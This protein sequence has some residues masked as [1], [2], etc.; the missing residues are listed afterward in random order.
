MREQKNIR[1]QYRRITAFMLAMLLVISG[2]ACSEKQD[3][4]KKE[5]PVV[6]DD[7]TVRQL[8]DFEDTVSVIDVQNNILYGYYVNDIYGYEGNASYG[9]FSYDLDTETMKK[10]AL[11]ENEKI[12]HMY[13]EDDHFAVEVQE[14]EQEDTNAAD[15]ISDNVDTSRT[16]ESKDSEKNITDE[17]NDNDD[18][19]DDSNN[20]FDYDADDIVI[21]C[22]YD[23]NLE[24]VSDNTQ[25]NANQV[26]E[27]SENE[28][29]TTVFRK[30]D[31][32]IRFISRDRIQVLDSAGKLLRSVD[33]SGMEI[34]NVIEQGDDRFLFLGLKAKEFSYS[35]YAFSLKENGTFE[36]LDE[37]NGSLVSI[38]R[39]NAKNSL[40]VS[41]DGYLYEYALDTKKITGILRYIDNGL[42][43]NKLT[44]A[45][46]MDEE[47]YVLIFFENP[48]FCSKLAILGKNGAGEKKKE[49][50]FATMLLSDQ[51]E[52]KID[53]FNMTNEQYRIVVDDYGKADEFPTAE[54]FEKG[55]LQFQLDILYGSGADIIDL[56][57]YVD[58]DHYTNKG[59]IEDLLPYIQRDEELR[60]EDFLPNILEAYKKDGKLYY[61]PSFFSVSCIMTTPEILGEDM[62]TDVSWT[63][64]EFMEYTQELPKDMRIF[65]TYHTCENLL[66]EFIADNM[67]TLIDWKKLTC[68]FNSEEFISLLEYCKDNFLTSSE[69]SE[70]ISGQEEFEWESTR[71]MKHQ[72][73]FTMAQ[74]TPGYFALN[75]QLFGEEPVVKG[76]PSGHGT[77]LYILDNSGL[78]I[79][80]NSRSKYK[81]VIW[82]FMRQWYLYDEQ[83]KIQ[84]GAL[85][86]Y[87]AYPV[88]KDCFDAYMENIKTEELKYEIDGKRY[89]LALDEGNRT[90]CVDR[91]T[92]EMIEQA[93]WLVEMADCTSE[94]VLSPVFDIIEEETESFFAGQKT[95]KETA[96]LIQSRVSIYVSEQG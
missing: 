42:D 50:H 58:L 52:R 49:I 20:D 72:V 66:R 44:Y 87:P 94:N 62:R 39:G 71:L 91:P 75:E 28:E 13:V 85:Y 68:H 59:I 56:A 45:Y 25:K 79:G 77:G 37:F 48:S 95:A 22:L 11:G 82:E 34:K 24:A 36:K 26:F 32:Q 67:E 86:S 60:E 54:E 18:S 46:P 57:H 84:L 23:R 33:V 16:A 35:L 10:T 21:R 6:V 47:H 19:N 31:Q 93:K 65:D 76:F 17:M 8:T 73:A 4:K 53:A 41:K 38:F 80:I 29:E 69:V 74:V 51:M 1:W 64:E 70:I 55:L 40:L 90:I 12:L 9:L 30:G 15:C 92:D 89:Y 83:S 7:Y 43:G 63:L 14:N 27:K 2:V 5:T 96:Q 88:R 61:L 81:D 78:M 3:S